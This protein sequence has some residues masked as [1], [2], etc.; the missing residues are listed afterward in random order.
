MNE[1]ESSAAKAKSISGEIAEIEYPELSLEDIDL[2]RR[3]CEIQSATSEEQ[4][5]GMIDAMTITK[6]VAFG[7]EILNSDELLNLVGRLGQLVEPVKAASWRNV[8]AVFRSG[9]AGEN[10]DNIE[11]ALHAWAEAFADGRLSSDEIY[12]QFEKIHPFADGN[13]RVGH[14]IWAFAEKRQ[15]KRWPSSLPPDV[16]SVDYKTDQHSAFGDIERA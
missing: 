10:P 2:A 14:C 13:G 8:P 3:Q 9:D 5:Q 15:N 6:S 12:Y 7:E 1:T 16:F 4:I 11:R